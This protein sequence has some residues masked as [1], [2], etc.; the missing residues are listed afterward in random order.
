VADGYIQLPADQAGKKLRTYVLPNGDHA[1]GVFLVDDQGNFVSSPESP[2]ASY[3]TSASLA[4]GASVTLDATAVTTAKTGQLQ[5]ILVGA[6]VP[7]KA[8]IRTVLAGTPT[9]RGV[10]FTTDA[11]L[12]ELFEPPDKHWYQLAGGAT[13]FYRVT[14]TNLDNVDA[15][16]VYATIWWDEVA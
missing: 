10:V 5:A 15:A 13:T 8:E 3:L 9:T 12:T 14:I 11:K 16:D 6:S 2:Q 7:L 1:E 4:A